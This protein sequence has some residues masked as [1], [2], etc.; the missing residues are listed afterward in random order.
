[1]TTSGNIYRLPLPRQKRDNVVMARSSETP[2]VLKEFEREHNLSQTKAAKRLGVELR[3]YQRWRA[4]DNFPVRGT[5][6][7]LASKMRREPEEFYAFGDSSSPETRERIARMEKRLEEVYEMVKDL[8]SESQHS[9]A[10]RSLEVAGQADPP[11]AAN[12]RTR[13]K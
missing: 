11:R 4:G 1:M 3:Q 2:R 8:H 9:T 5:V 6:E 13:K 10:S 7:R 12:G